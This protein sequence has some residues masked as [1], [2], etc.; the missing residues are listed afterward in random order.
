MKPKTSLEKTVERS[1]TRRRFLKGAAGALGLLGAPAFIRNAG[2]STMRK[3]KFQLAWLLSGQYTFALA[4]KE[5]GYW[6]EQGLDVEISRGFGSGRTATSIATGQFEVGEASFSI[7]AH[8]VSKGASLVAIGA[9]FQKSPIGI[10]ALKK[11]GMKTPKDLE[12]MRVGSAADSGAYVLFPAFAK[13]TGIDTSKVKFQVISPAAYLS[14]MLA[15]QVDAVATYYTSQAPIL[16]SKGLAFDYLFL[17]DYGL[18]MLE[19]SFITQPGR[20]KED[21][22]L[23]RKFT[24][25]VLKGMAYSYLEPDKAVDITM[26]HL[27]TTESRSL[28]EIGQGAATAL[29]LSPVVEEKGIGWMEPALVKDTVDKVVRYMG[30]P[31]IEDVEALYTNDF[32]GKVRLTADQWKKVKGY[33]QKYLPS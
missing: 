29:G 15:D 11:K 25:G 7:V 6:A 16:L 14:S 18:D 21:R 28:I 4:A 17:A 27:P 19:L 33:S 20:L 23:Y 1:F 26:K 9:R 12:G 8:T 22:E 24:E 30:A 5:L 31:K 10:M 13:A 2:P 32:I 3:V